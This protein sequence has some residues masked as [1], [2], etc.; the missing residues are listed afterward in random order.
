MREAGTV[1]TGLVPCARSAATKES[2]DVES[3]MFSK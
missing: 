1:T 2:S 3:T